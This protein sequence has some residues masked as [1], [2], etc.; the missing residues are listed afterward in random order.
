[1]TNVRHTTKTERGIRM[2]YRVKDS[3]VTWDGFGVRQM[4]RRQPVGA[5]CP[6]QE[7]GRKGKERRR[8]H[9]NTGRGYRQ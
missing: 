5:L 1:M 3:F 6:G 7:T 8:N 9:G 4:R 2:A